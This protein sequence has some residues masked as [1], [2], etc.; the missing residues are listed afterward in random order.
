MKKAISLFLVHKI[1]VLNLLCAL[2]ATGLG[3][4]SFS[5]GF[6]V[7]SLFVIYLN[8]PIPGRK[9]FYVGLVLLSIILSV[10]VLA[11]KQ[12]S[13]LGRLLIYK[14]TF[15]MFRDHWQYGV[16]LGQFSLN[17]LKYQAAYFN[18]PGFTTKELLLA[19]NTQHAFNDYWQFILERGIAGVIVLIIVFA[20]IVKTIYRALKLTNGSSI[21][22]FAASLLLAISIAALFMHVFEGFIARI[23]FMAALVTVFYYNAQSNLKVYLT[24]IMLSLLLVTFFHWKSY[25]IRYSEYQKFRNAEI[26]YKAGYIVDAEKIYCQLFKAL[27]SDADYL[28]GYA[29]VLSTYGNTLKAERLL[30]KAVAIQ[31]NN[32]YYNQ[33]AYVYYL[34]KKNEKAEQA[35]LLA[36]HMVPNRFVTRFGLYNFYKNT[37]QSKKAIKIRADILSLPVKIPSI[38]IDFI[39]Q[40]LQSDA[41]VSFM[42]Q[43]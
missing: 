17:Y 33:L 20:V 35:Y 43:Y 24:A 10:S 39:R 19:D 40:S 13:S 9:V 36:V 3:S 22:V 42:K 14:V 11:F 32:M 5:I 26:L 4:R 18:H 27:E 28:V 12:D 41:I 38:E 8:Y 25:L 34:N 37:N 2:I 6:L 16:G 29:N 7:S 30:E 23:T 1:I 31:S 21:V 15:I